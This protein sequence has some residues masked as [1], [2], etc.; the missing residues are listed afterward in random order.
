MPTTSGLATERRHARLAGAAYLV[1]IVLGLLGEV[2]V[3]AGM[4]AWDDPMAT[5]R[6]IAD[7]HLLFR[8]T[9]A[10]D[11]V[12]LMADALVGVILWTL[13]RRF[14]QGV[15]TLALVLRLLHTAVYGAGL[16]GLLEVVHLVGGGAA[17]AGLTAIELP[18][19]VM[20]ALQRQVFGYL[21]GLVFFGL[22]CGVLGWLIVRSRRFPAWLGW[23]LIVAAA[24]YLVDC[25]AQ[26]LVPDYRAMQDVFQAI[27]LFPALVAELSMG[28]Y[29]LIKGV[30]REA[31]D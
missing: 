23:L 15:A 29:L 30:R 14:N 2:G 10:T 12:M 22:H 11:L 20:L 7:D 21:V 5:A 31:A 16:F 26:F 13:L 28:L 6:R 9:I 1:I 24:G 8:V 25:F 19:L 27:V 4:I 3:R 17:P 18:G